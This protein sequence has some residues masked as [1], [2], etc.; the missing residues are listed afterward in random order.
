MHRLSLAAVL[1]TAIPSSGQS[2]LFVVTTDFSTGSAAF[3][4]AGAAEAEV[5]LLGVHSDAAG[6]YHD[7]R[8]YV[9]N[10]LGQDNILV[11]DETDLRAPLTQFSVGNGANPHDIEI[12]APGKAYVTLYETASLLIVDPRDGARLGEIDLGA[13][14]DGDGLPEVSQIVRVG[15]RLY[16]SCQRLDRNGTWGPVDVSYLI[17]VDLAGD[18][19]VDVDPATEGVQGIALSA[20]N[21]NSLAVFGERIAVGSVV[22]FG[23]R[24]GGVE[25]VDAAA[26]RSLGL[27]VS[28]E[29]LGGDITS[30]VLADGK[31]GYAV[32]ADEDF[33]NSVRPFDLETGSVGEPLENTSGGFIPHLAVDGGR[34][35]VADRGSWDDPDSAGLKLYD[36]ATGAFLG[37]PV[38]TGL[39]PMHVVVLSDAAPTA[40]EETAGRGRPREFALGAAWPNPFNA[41]VHIPFAVGRADTPVELTVRDLLG[42][43]VR[44]LAAGPAAAGRHV[45]SWD[46]RD[47]A[48]E[49]VGNGAYLVH[50]RAG[51]RRAA[52]KV[53]LIK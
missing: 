23:D 35:I 28:E 45:F 4:A 32:V 39:P 52:G 14:A 41:S 37:G 16:L 7:G 47:D 20:A 26:N 51:D 10:R 50:L 24:A 30:M 36:A 18:T 11:L 1:L 31:R 5:N 15:K 33:V 6:H 3:L 48:G 21:P 42:R 27:A 8:V 12:V 13:F 22:N 2:G 34:L 44:T 40:V 49:P 38:S 9:I 43:T 29:D 46:G 25:I 53:M 19:L 17:V